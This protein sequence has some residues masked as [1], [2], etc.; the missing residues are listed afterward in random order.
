MAK[1]FK[2]I[3]TIIGSTVGVAIL[4]GGIYGGLWVARHVKNS[5]PEQ[6]VNKPFEP[7][8]GSN[9]SHPDHN[10]LPPSPTIPPSSGDVFN[11]VDIRLSPSGP[12]QEGSKITA[13][14]IPN[15]PVDGGLWDWHIEGGVQLIGSKGL[16][17]TFD[18]YRQEN[19]KKLV[20]TCNGISGSVILN[21]TNKPGTPSDPNY[22][23]VSRLDS[24]TI[25]DIKNEYLVGGQIQPVPTVKAEGKIDNTTFEWYING[26][27]VSNEEVPIFDV[28]DTKWNGATLKC[29]AKLNGH[30]KE[31]S[32]VLHIRERR[33]SDPD[34]VLADTIKKHNLVYKLKKKA[35]G[36]VYAVAISQDIFSGYPRLDQLAD[37]DEGLIDYTEGDKHYHVYLEEIGE[38]NGTRAL[39]EN[40]LGT[41]LK[42]PHSVK[43]I[44]K[45]AFFGQTSLRYVHLWGDSLQEICERAF[46]NCNRLSFVMDFP[47]SLRVIG[48]EA[49]AGCDLRETQ[50]LT[51]NNVQIGDS[52]FYRTGLYKAIIKGTTTF[53]EGDFNPATK[54]ERVK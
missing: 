21:I 3:K 40:W 32:I 34:I 35:D 4:C 47:K 30:T 13:T 26:K 44:N 6:T 39:S 28:V 27:L 16:T 31:D 52:A 24:V 36:T 41:A 18:A 45:T 29:I 49:F 53:K 14:A 19:G 38:E 20:A 46:F 54:I 51:F 17:V 42:I 9:A 15:V 10:T 8:H 7:S 43:K 37:N 22:D 25:N 1:A 12:V 5:K 48:K 50:S 2:V 23:A 33:P 11:H